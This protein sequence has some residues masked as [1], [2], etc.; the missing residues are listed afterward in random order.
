MEWKIYQPTPL[1]PS[2][3]QPALNLYNL[4]ATTSRLIGEITC[5]DP[6]L[7][8]LDQDV[9]A[10]SESNYVRAYHN[11][12]LYLLFTSFDKGYVYV[13]V[14]SSTQKCAEIAF[15]NVPATLTIQNN[16]TIKDFVTKTSKTVYQFKE[17][18]A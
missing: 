3:R 9:I 2:S 14:A 12:V 1:A 8:T 5:N 10:Y 15:T 13:D 6:Q 18:P 7:T 11:N 4:E 17:I 16:A